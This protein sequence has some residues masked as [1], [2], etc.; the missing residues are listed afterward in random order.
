MKVVLIIEYVINLSL[1]L[2]FGMHMFQLNSY[3]Y[4]K[5]LRWLGKN[6]KKLLIQLILI[7]IPSALILLNNTVADVFAIIFLAI[8]IIYNMPKHKAKISLKYTHRVIRMF[9]TEAIIVIAC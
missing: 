4:K 3:S 9:I 6:I 2:F 5:H 8:S 1:L 7:G